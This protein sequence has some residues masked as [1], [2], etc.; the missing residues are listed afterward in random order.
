MITYNRPAVLLETLKVI[1][2]QSVAPELIWVIDN[3]EGMETDHAIASILDPRIKY[4][5]MGYNS[6]P[7][8]AS[9][10]GLELCAE[11]NLDWI[12][13][14]D[15]NDP[16]EFEDTFERLLSVKDDNPYCGIIGAVGHFFDYK[17]GEIKRVQTRLLKKKRSIEVETIAG[18]MNML[19]HRDVV[20]AGVLPDSDLFFGFEELDFCLKAKRK[21][22]ALVVNC[23]LF[24]RLREKHNRT[25]FKRE[26][27]KKKAN[28]GREYYSLRNLLYISNSLTSKA[29]KKRLIV[30]WI[31]KAFYGFRYGLNYG[32]RNF[33]TIL[34]AFYHYW[35]GI[36]GKTIDLIP[37][38]ES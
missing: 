31:G 14:G 22:F 15:D 24:I 16:P 29:M 9:K 32:A 37:A 35:R 6:G 25:D 7:A 11:E 12:Y 13:W 28:P 2:A 23:E 21:G 27:Y 17:K 26:F 34:L 1:F 8:G 30:K 19:V 3:S 33:K 36:K 4:H 5:R 38:N 20:K 18:G 10:K